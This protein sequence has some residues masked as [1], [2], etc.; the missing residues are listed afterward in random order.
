MNSSIGTYAESIYTM[1][2]S[3]GTLIATIKAQLCHYGAGNAILHVKRRLEV[4]ALHQTNVTSK[5]ADTI[6]EL[7]DKMGARYP[8]T[9]VRQVLECL[10]VGT[11]TAIGYMIIG[12]RMRCY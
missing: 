7:F 1:T 11:F 9:L 6:V 10:F 3:I 8:H 2:S 5:N 4:N 12:R